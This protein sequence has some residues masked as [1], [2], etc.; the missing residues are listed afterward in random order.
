VVDTVFNVCA[1]NVCQKLALLRQGVNTIPKLQ[2]LGTKRDDLINKLK[3]STSLPLNRR[4]CEFTVDA[5]TNLTA[6]V[7]F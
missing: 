1:L 4:G 2:L 7:L 6:L 5:V 3:P